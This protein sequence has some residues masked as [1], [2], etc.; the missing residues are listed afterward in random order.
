MQKKLFQLLIIGLIVILLNCFIASETSAEEKLYYVHSDHLGSTSLVTDEGGNVISQ[1]SYFPY[2]ETRASTSSSPTERQYTGQISDTDQTGLYYYNARYYNPQTALF[3]QADM[4]NDDLNKYTYVS[5]NPI[6]L[7]D[8]SGHQGQ[9]SAEDYLTNRL[10][11]RSSAVAVIDMAESLVTSIKSEYANYGL[12][13]SESRMQK[14]WPLLGEILGSNNW[15]YNQYDIAS[16]NRTQIGNMNLALALAVSGQES[17]WGEL[18]GFP[19]NAHFGEFLQSS[20][21]MEKYV[22]ESGYCFY[23]ES[24]KEWDFWSSSASEIY[25]TNFEAIDRYPREDNFGNFVSFIYAMRMRLGY[26]GAKGIVNLIDSEGNIADIHLLSG[27]YNLGSYSEQRKLWETNVLKYYNILKELA[28][29]Y[30][31]EYGYLLEDWK[32][33]KSPPP[34]P[35]NEK[36]VP[37]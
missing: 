16:F 27:Y 13:I 32:D 28:L 10:G 23:D 17:T 2:G 24:A 7:I 11:S 1:Q 20:L 26:S 6:N 33:F 14:L 19:F 34:L 35:S 37:N 12:I 15:K 31:D 18:S 29:L 22:N 8:P 30:P 25:D 5:G 21:I 36:Y 9:K 3:T 4:V